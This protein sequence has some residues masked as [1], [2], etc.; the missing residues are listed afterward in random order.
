MGNESSN[1]PWEERS[2]YSRR[3]DLCGKTKVLASEV[4]FVFPWQ[5]HINLQRGYSKDDILGFRRAHTRG[6]LNFENL[7]S[8][9]DTESLIRKIR[10]KEQVGTSQIE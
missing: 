8:V 6:S 7:Y 5:L 1:L 3:R 2:C 10:G 4:G 9:E